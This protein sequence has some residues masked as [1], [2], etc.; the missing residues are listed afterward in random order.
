MTESE[1][2]KAKC[3]S[4]KN[5]QTKIDKREEGK[6]G[7]SILRGRGKEEGERSI[8]GKSS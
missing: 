2:E 7:H 8:I 1:G 4:G 3:Q 6:Q 5:E